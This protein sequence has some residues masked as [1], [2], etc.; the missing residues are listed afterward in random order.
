MAFIE[1]PRFPDHI[2]RGSKGGPTWLTDV[3]TVT[4][5]REQR[6][7]RWSRQRHTYDAAFGIR[8]MSDLEEVVD[9]FYGARGRLHGFRY[10]DW[11][12]FRSSGSES[13]PSALDQTIGVGDGAQTQFQLLKIYK[14]VGTAQG[15]ARAITKPVAGTVL[16]ALDS[17]EQP[18]GW[19]V[20][21]ATGLVT[22]DTAPGAGVVITAGYEFDVPCRFDSDEIS[23]QLE[24]YDVG[25]TQ[26]PLVEIR[27]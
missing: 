6:N 2:S 20:D 23:T 15:Y 3:V 4:S 10:K 12:D 25:G 26:I 14:Y 7:Q 27:V 11:G 18:S 16:I 5:G 13:S 24:I 22:F 19:T 8:D 1:T 21:A 17:V 9:Y